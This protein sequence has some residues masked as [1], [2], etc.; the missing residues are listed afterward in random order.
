[1]RI[2][3][4]NSSPEVT[5]MTS[6]VAIGGLLTIDRALPFYT[7]LLSGPSTS[8]LPVR[9]R[10]VPIPGGGLS[11]LPECYGHLEAKVLKAQERLQE[12]IVLIGHSMGG[13]IAT[14]IGLEHPDKVSGVICLAGLQEGIRHETLSSLILRTA[15]RNPPGGEDIKHDSDFMKKHKQ[16]IATDWS[17]DTSLHLVSP[18]I[19][20]V[21]LLPQGLG[22]EMPAGQTADR[23]YAG[24]PLPGVEFLLR[25]VPGMPKDIKLLA[26]IP[27]SHADI[28]ISPN[29]V[30]YTRRLRVPPAVD[31]EISKISP[32][33]ELDSL[34]LAA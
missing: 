26:S 4:L 33:L 21:L 6:A 12:R 3:K 31:S 13:L 17:P 28:A 14:M 23:R 18:T 8:D 11:T 34:P 24:L 19:D 27:T 9:D 16:R 25:R 30:G 20:D 29:V 15:L 22:L 5:V 2:N 1:M 32:P 10:F 7:P